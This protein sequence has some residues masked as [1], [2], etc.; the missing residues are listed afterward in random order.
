MD[1]DLTE[2][3]LMITS[4][5]DLVIEK[6]PRDAFF[7]IAALAENADQFYAA[8]SMQIQLQEI[9]RDHYQSEDT[10]AQY[11]TE[12]AYRCGPDENRHRR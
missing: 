6:A 3:E 2:F 8:A 4:I 10:E 12:A 7:D 9:V 1:P 11:G 5:A